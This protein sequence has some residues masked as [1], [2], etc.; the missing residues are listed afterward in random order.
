MLKVGD[1]IFVSGG[2]HQV[3]SWLLDGKGY[4]ATVAGFRLNT[5]ILHSRDMIARLNHRIKIGDLEGDALLLSLRYI[6]SRWDDSEVA[7]VD[8]LTTVPRMRNWFLYQRW[9]IKNSLWVESHATY[10]KIINE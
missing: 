5:L 6:G 9:L 3:P 8:L 7:H 4:Y 2:Y 10:N 1:R